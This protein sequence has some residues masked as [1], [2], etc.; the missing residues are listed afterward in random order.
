MVE[1]TSTYVAG[2]VAE[3]MWVG[4]L[5][6]KKSL[7]LS[8]SRMRKQIRQ[9]RKP[10]DGGSEELLIHGTASKL[11]KKSEKNLNSAT[12]CSNSPR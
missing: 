5:R 9:E 10:E 8:L 1:S 3:A 7:S 6:Q 4:L 11:F 12:L 2:L